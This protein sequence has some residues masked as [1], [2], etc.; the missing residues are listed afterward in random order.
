MDFMYLTATRN[1]LDSLFA[2]LCVIWLSC[3]KVSPV[4]GAVPYVP[5][6]STA[7]ALGECF[8]NKLIHRN[9]TSVLEVRCSARHF[10]LVSSLQE[11]C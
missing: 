11:L 6:P 1:D 3:G 7:W 8:V 9:K 5:V 2:S 10:P 4:R